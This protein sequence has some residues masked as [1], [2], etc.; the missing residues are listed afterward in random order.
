MPCIISF[1]KCFF[2]WILC[3]ENGSSKLKNSLQ[4]L[5]KIR[6]L[7]V[8]NWGLNK[9]QEIHSMYCMRMMT[10]TP[11]ETA[12]YL[13]TQ[14]FPDDD[15]STDTLSQHS[16]RVRSKSALLDSTDDP[17]FTATELSSVILSFDTKKAPGLDGFNAAII[18]RIHTVTPSLLLTLFNLC[19]SMGHFP[20]EWKT[21]AVKLLPKPGQPED[22]HKANRPISLLLLLGKCLEKLVSSRLTWYA[23]TK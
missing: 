17:H 4:C 20:K 22:T 23:L 6:I 2:T 15:P 3:L 12:D 11:A 9:D 14:Y 18:E 10:A 16:D 8:Y 5:R 1:T 7:N 19:L 21:V 13:L